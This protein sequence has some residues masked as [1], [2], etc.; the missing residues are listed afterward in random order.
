MFQLKHICVVVFTAHSFTPLTLDD[1]AQELC[2]LKGMAP[3][4]E[5]PLYTTE[6][7]FRRA[8]S[9]AAVAE[10]ALPG[11]PP[12]P[13]SAETDPVYTYGALFLAMGLAMAYRATRPADRLTAASE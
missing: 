6:E 10:L 5:M 9:Q 7:E 3:A 2:K 8:V 13:P 12:A 11:V 1:I 4:G